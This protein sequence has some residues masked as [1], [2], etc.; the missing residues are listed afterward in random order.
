MSWD[1][2]PWF[3]G[4]GAEHS[5]EVARLLAYAATGGAEGIVTPGDLKV[6]PYA[7]PGAG[8]RAAAGAALI[9]NRA[10]GGTA[11]TYAARNPTVD[12]VE[13]APT[14]SAGGRSDLIV[15]QIEDPHMAG[16]TW[17]EPADPK[18]GPYIFTRVI[19]NVPAGTTRLRDLP[20][21]SGRS[22][23]VLARID[24]PASTGTVTAA[25]I[26]D[27][28]KVARPRQARA[29]GTVAPTSAGRGWMNPTTETL[30]PNRALSV[31]V[32]EWATKV[33][34]TGSL[35]GVLQF[36]GNADL[37]GFLRLGAGTGSVSGVAFNFVLEADPTD[38]Q[39]TTLVFTMEVAVPAAMRGTT[40][41]LGLYAFRNGTAAGRYGTDGATRL[42]LDATFS[43][44]AA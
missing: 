23:V 33:V 43:E 32:P 34:V 2:V 4:G 44:A 5:P 28:R 7:V 36:F 10:A 12:T 29:V 19:P 22:A 18:V 25:M 6:S 40:Q 24:L 13:I 27:L 1:S 35:V 26:S 9:L 37:T 8:V 14:G 38:K 3:V 21:Y 20:G 42:V 31:D 15:A 11:Q 41:P 16:E 30:W 39:R 17:D